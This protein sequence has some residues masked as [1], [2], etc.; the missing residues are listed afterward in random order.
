MNVITPATRL[1]LTLSMLKGV[2]PAS[3]KKVAAISGFVNENPEAL[4]RNISQIARALEPDDAWQEAC[5]KAEQ[6]IEAAEKHQARILS[7]VDQEYPHRLT[8]TKDDPFILYVKG[9]LAPKSMHTVAIIGTREP[10][11]HG[12]KIARRISQFFAENGSSIVSGLALG[13]DAI[14]HQTALEFGGH[15][16]AVLA[17][18]L[19]TIAPSKH[20]KL[21]EQI[22]EAGG[23]LVSEYPFGQSAQAQQFVKRDRTQAGLADGVI[24]IQSDLKGGSLHASRSALEYGRWLAVPYPTDRDLGNN[25]P[26]VQ[27][28]LLVAEG[29]PRPKAELLRCTEADLERIIVLRSREDY[30]C[31]LGEPPKS[32]STSVKVAAPEPTDVLSNKSPEALASQTQMNLAELTKALAA[33]VI[34]RPPEE[35][36]VKL[37]IKWRNHSVPNVT[38]ALATI[39]KF[40]S[41]ALEEPD[42]GLATETMYRI[43]FLQKRLDDIA[44]LRLQSHTSVEKAKFL[45][46]SV[47]DAWLHMKYVMDFATHSRFKSWLLSQYRFQH[48][49]EDQMSIFHAGSEVHE[50][51]TIDELSTLLHAHVAAAIME[52]ELSNSTP[53]HCSRGANVNFDDLVYWFND[54]LSLPVEQ[55]KELR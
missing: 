38:N 1:L 28:N 24:M 12:V 36:T 27:A 21:A 34:I 26:K 41:R 7:A 43:K 40:N 4:G 5:K 25:E 42:S 53:N 35:G 8:A 39:E 14:A 13:C 54:S 37:L 51:K 16:V 46:F 18:G 19:Q 20:K 33:K 44:E 9:T 11:E 48:L 47:E 23:A 45:Q 22:L 30:Q 6:Q 17:H 29:A 52:D 49:S 55:L 10:T 31:L 15:T 2:G 3:L 50:K 32:D